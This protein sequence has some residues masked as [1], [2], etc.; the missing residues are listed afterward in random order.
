MYASMRAEAACMRTK[1]ACTCAPRQPAY[2]RAEAACMRAKA[3]FCAYR[4]A[5]ICRGLRPR[6][7]WPA[8]YMLVARQAG[9]APP[10]W[11]EADAP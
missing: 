8:I 1:A 4:P 3:G 10:R 6:N 5:D 9:G 7:W 2:V 11:V